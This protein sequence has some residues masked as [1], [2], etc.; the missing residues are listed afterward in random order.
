[1]R[2]LA[3][4]TLCYDQIFARHGSPGD[5]RRPST[6]PAIGTVTIDQRKRPALQNVSC[7]AANASTS[8]L[9]KI[10]LAQF[11]HESTLLC[12]DTSRNAFMAIRALL[13]LVAR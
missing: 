1:M 9:H 10:R 4:F 2:N 7:P 3:R 12:K 8:H 6:S 5:I 13:A 11:N